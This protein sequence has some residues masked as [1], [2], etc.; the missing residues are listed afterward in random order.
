MK[1]VEYLKRLGNV[2]E[3]ITVIHVVDEKELVGTS[4]LDVQKTRKEVRARLEEICA[5]FEA[6]GIRSRGRIYVGNA[7]DEIDKA[8]RECQSTMI[9]LGSS[10]KSRWMEKW[11][12][13]TPRS[14][15]EKSIYPTL[16]IPPEKG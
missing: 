16:L 6:E 4:S 7:E 12:G 14:I 9:V 2:A 5:V 13:S 3:E 1:A 15:A 10:A 11:L 8:A